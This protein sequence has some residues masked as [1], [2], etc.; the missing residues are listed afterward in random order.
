MKIQKVTQVVSAGGVVCKSIGRGNRICLIAR[1]KGEIWALPKG[2]IEKGEKLVE[3]ACREVLE[4]TGLKA[5]PLRKIGL[6]RYT[7]VSGKTKYRKRV[8]F[9][10]FRYRGGSTRRHDSEVDEARWFSLRQAL[11]KM[12]YPSEKKIVERAHAMLS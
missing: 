12:S 4:E 9:F 3:A 11:R 10:L 2:H 6:I 5:I 8:H 7:F 1:R